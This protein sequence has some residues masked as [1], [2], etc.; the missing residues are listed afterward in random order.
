MVVR[1][2]RKR[3]AMCGYEPYFFFFNLN[4]PMQGYF[5]TGR[6]LL[7]GTQCGFFTLYLSA[8]A[9]VILVGAALL[10]VADRLEHVEGEYD[11]INASGAN[12]SSPSFQQEIWRSY[13]YFIDPGT[14]TDLAP[15]SNAPLH[16]VVAVAC[17]LIGFTWVLVVFGTV[18]EVTSQAVAEW[19]LMNSR[20]LTSDHI[21]V[22]GWTDKTLFLIGELAQQL[23]DDG[24]PRGG[25]IGM[26]GLRRWLGSSRRRRRCGGGE[27]VVLGNIPT[28]EMREEVFR[29]SFP[30]WHDDFPRVT[31][32]FWS[33]KPYEIDDLERVSVRTARK[34]IA[35]GSSADPRVG[36]R[37]PSRSSAHCG[38]ACLSIAASHTRRPPPLPPP[39]P[40][41]RRSWWRSPNSR[42][43]R[44]S[45]NSP[46]GPHARATP[47]RRSTHSWWS[48]RVSRASRKRS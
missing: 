40:T 23:T 20:I 28:A 15:E 10:T 39:P 31:L 42:T 18:V 44:S 36:T 1:V 43:R 21:L 3:N 7:L 26:F 25:A 6:V 12:G 41:R 4:Q 30:T 35:L 14:Q 17:S 2:V 47:P 46:R 29:V 9:I 32:R 13:T 45:I 5:S 34:I 19:R 38:V 24:V 16:F 27:I 11:G 37:R 8:A 22:L 48:V 33:G